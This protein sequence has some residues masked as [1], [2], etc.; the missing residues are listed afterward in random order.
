MTAHTVTNMHGMQ[1]TVQTN[2][3]PSLAWTKLGRPPQKRKFSAL[4]LGY[5]RRLLIMLR[6]APIAC[7]HQASRGAVIR[8][9]IHATR[10][11]NENIGWYL[12][13]R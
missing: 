13:N 1:G 4:A 8:P 12:P 10:R 9:P 6:S 2:N 11:K 3:S 7:T 5:F